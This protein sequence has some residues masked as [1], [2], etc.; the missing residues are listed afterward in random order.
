MET[1]DLFGRN[2]GNIWVRSAV[3]QKDGLVIRACNTEKG[4]TVSGRRL[5][6][7]KVAFSPD[8]DVLFTSD[9]LG[10]VYRFDLEKNRYIHNMPISCNRTIFHVNDVQNPRHCC[11]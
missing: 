4:A 6:F 9:Y 1:V 2:E 11:Y 3:I 8:N 5:S 7:T 10:N